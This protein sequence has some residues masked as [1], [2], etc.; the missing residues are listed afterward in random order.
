MESVHVIAALSG[1]G[2]KVITNKAESEVLSSYV[3]PFVSEGTLT[4]TWAGKTQTRQALEL[5]IYKTDTPYAP[6]SGVDLETFVKGKRNRFNALAK[7]AE[8]QLGRAKSRVFV[9]MPIQGDEYG[10]QEQQRIFKEFDERFKALEQVLR[11]LDCV[12]IRIDKEQPLEGIVDRIKKEINRASFL[13][14]DLT[15]ER[16]SC[17]YEIGFADGLE[18]PVICVASENSV[19]SPGSKTR[20]HFDIHRHVLTFTNHGQ[21][22]E[23]VKAAFEKNRA[24]L[25]ADR[26]KTESLDLSD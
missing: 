8:K 14:A 25:T 24:I 12:A 13:V 5:R 10:G 11:E 22:K 19:L 26:G 1:G 17:Y 2:R 21:L 16:P 6:K 9:V 23:K 18:I 4:T 20:I 3:V 15:D 7:K